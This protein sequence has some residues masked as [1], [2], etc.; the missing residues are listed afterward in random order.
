[1]TALATSEY[2]QSGGAVAD[3]KS[4]NPFAQSDDLAGE[5]MAKDTT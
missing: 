1:V 2:R 4:L 3:V 5:L